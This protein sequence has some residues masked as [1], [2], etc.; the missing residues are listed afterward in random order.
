MTGG[1]CRRAGRSLVSL[2]L[3]L[4]HVSAVHDLLLHLLL[5]DLPS[6]HLLLVLFELGLQLQLVE[7]LERRGVV[8]DRLCTT[9]L[10]CSSFVLRLALLLGSRRIVELLLSH[11]LSY[12][13]LCAIWVVVCGLL[14]LLLF[15]RP[16]VLDQALAEENR[17][18]EQRDLRN[19]WLHV[20]G[21]CLPLALL[22][23]PL[24]PPLALVLLVRLLLLLAQLVFPRI[25][26]ALLLPERIP[27]RRKKQEAYQE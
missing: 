12:Q 3:L 6:C 16:L 21:I 22:R 9:T 18:L 7:Q 8:L 27:Q 15:H 20:D 25:E 11:V 26:I 4:L 24:G 14:L 10:L 23:L 2:L 1:P 19:I 5:V 13:D 17:L